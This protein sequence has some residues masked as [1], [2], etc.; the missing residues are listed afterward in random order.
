MG[1][2]DPLWACGAIGV[3][4][5][6]RLALSLLLLHRLEGVPVM[7]IVARQWRPLVAALPM[8][9]AIVG[10]RRLFAAHGL[11]AAHGIHA[12][13]QLAAEVAAGGLAYAATALVVA[14]AASR[15]LIDLALR[16]ARRRGSED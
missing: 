16:V 11:G 2:I 9:A 14:R 10:L 5:T 15:D 8:V 7:P 6:A 1:R 3:A 13:P 12:A 4:F